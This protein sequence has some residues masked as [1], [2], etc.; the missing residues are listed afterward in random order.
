MHVLGYRIQQYLGLSR[1]NQREILHEMRGL[2]L[3]FHPLVDFMGFVEGYFLGSR[4][5][6]SNIT[7]DSLFN[8]SSNFF[9]KG[10]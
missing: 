7:K 9:L 5:L 6:V 3:Y 2:T 4:S 8:S 1:K 10:I